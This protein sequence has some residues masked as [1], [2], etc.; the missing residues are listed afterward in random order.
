MPELWDI[1]LDDEDLEALRELQ[2]KRGLRCE[3]VEDAGV[4]SALATAQLT[5]VPGVDYFRALIDAFEGAERFERLNAEDGPYWWIEVLRSV[6]KKGTK[7]EAARVL[8]RVLQVLVS[9][10]R[11]YVR[12]A[13]RGVE[14]MLARP[15][16]SGI[17]L[18]FEPSRAACE[19]TKANRRL[20]TRVEEGGSGEGGRVEGGEG[21]PDKGLRI[22][23]SLT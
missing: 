20:R 19:T 9:Q 14:A 4:F 23:L 13:I 11:L 3:Q 5:K 2:K 8:A 17:G 12:S 22:V 10:S 21:G 18:D 15:A 7:L 6:G 1:G 16:C